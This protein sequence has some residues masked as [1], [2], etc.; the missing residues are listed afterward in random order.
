MPH[1]LMRTRAVLLVTLVSISTVAAQPL[2]AASRT[3]FKCTQNGKVIYSDEPCLGAERLDAEPTRGADH[4]SGKAKTGKDVQREK[5]REGFAEAVR[6]LTGMN[7]R[8]F[9]VA[10]KRNQLSVEAKR[11]CA[12]LD[13][14]IPV[15]EMSERSAT[16]NSLLPSQQELL[17]LRKRFRELSC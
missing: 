1:W 2:P 16:G 3:V 6:P 4:L 15:A 17:R 5:N 7:S 11:E 13:R 12:Q 9:D 10:V 14:Q 8:Q